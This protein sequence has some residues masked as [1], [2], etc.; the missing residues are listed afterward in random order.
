MKKQQRLLGSIMFLLIGIFLTLLYITKM[1][2]C[3]LVSYSAVAF[4][5][6]GVCY[7]TLEFFLGKESE[8]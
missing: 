2:P 7:G 3:N 5:G 1:V 8:N 6:F 4:G